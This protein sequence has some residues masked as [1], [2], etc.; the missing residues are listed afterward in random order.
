MT[1]YAAC[2]YGNHFLL[3]SALSDDEG[4]AEVIADAW[5]N[6]R[7]ALHDIL[8]LAEQILQERHPELWPCALRAAR[9]WLGLVDFSAR[10]Q[11]ALETGL[12]DAVEVCSTR[13]DVSAHGL[14]AA[15]DCLEWARSGDLGKDGARWKKVAE[16]ARQCSKAEVAE[17]A[18]RLMEIAL[19]WEPEVVADDV[20]LAMEPTPTVITVAQWMDIE[21]DA[22]VVT[23][24]PITPPQPPPQ[25]QRTHHRRRWLI[26]ALINGG[27]VAITF[28]WLYWLWKRRQTLF[29]L[30]SQ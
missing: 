12:S 16:I 29:K 2:G 23:T 24:K 7:A 1:I 27:I 11:L 26:V 22:K 4:G 6:A 21:E 18:E 19:I 20:A 9:A 10:A 13:F 28:A 8:D 5:N 3:Q 30:I 17:E 15:M 25:P 14:A